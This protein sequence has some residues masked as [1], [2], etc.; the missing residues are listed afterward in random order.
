MVHFECD[1]VPFMNYPADYYILEMK[2]IGTGNEWWYWFSYGY[3]N[4]NYTMENVSNDSY[5]R[6]RSVRNGITSNPSNEIFV[7]GDPNEY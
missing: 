2:N 5:Y 7:T 6:L 3:P 1:E 4:F